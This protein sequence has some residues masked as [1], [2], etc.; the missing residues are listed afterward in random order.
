M[1]IIEQE[2]EQNFFNTDK[3][4]IRALEIKEKLLTWNIGELFIQETIENIATV[5]RLDAVR[6]RKLEDFWGNIFSSPDR[7]SVTNC[8][9]SQIVIMIRLMNKRNLHL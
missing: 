2:K 9:K 6:I 1:T 5:T 4:I 3:Y 7:I 8:V